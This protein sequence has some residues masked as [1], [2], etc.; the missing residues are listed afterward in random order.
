MTGMTINGRTFTPEEV[1]TAYPHQPGTY[2]N[3]PEPSHYSLVNWNPYFVADY[4]IPG[5]NFI[6]IT[7]ITENPWEERPF[8]LYARFQ[9]Q[10][11]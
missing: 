5:P 4:F 3:I 11:P 8:D 7:L 9:V 6:E 2:L 1:D 10:T